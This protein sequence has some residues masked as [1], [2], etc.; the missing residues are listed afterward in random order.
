[1]E[2]GSTQGLPAETPRTETVDIGPES[3]E[4]PSRSDKRP[5]RRLPWW[6]GLVLALGIG[7][8][9]LLIAARSQPTDSA[10]SEPIEAAGNAVAEVSGEADGPSRMNVPVADPA[11]TSEIQADLAGALTGNWPEDLWLAVRQGPAI[12]AIHVESGE[13]QPM[14][15]PGRADGDG[16]LASLDGQL[17]YVH[18]ASAWL[19]GLGGEST[20]LGLADRVQPAAN[21]AHVWLGVD[22]PSTSDDPEAFV[23]WSEV[24]ATG[25][26]YRTTRREVD[27]EFAHPDLV[28]GFDSNLYR[29]EARDVHPW[30]HI[31]QGFPVAVGPNDLILNICTPER[32]C[33]RRWFDGQTGQDR[34]QLMADV[35]DNVAERYGGQLSPNGRFV[36]HDGELGRAMVRSTA[37]GELVTSACLRHDALAWAPGDA[38]LA[39]ESE[40]G[41]L[42]ATPNAATV[43]IETS[44]TAF[45]FIS[46]T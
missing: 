8:V 9:A 41:L 3:H 1:M 28:G 13:V 31:A 6:M 2:G 5:T 37:S 19:V 14:P 18:G 43:V 10:A 22:E 25:T 15:I 12:Q 4:R 17:V 46:G 16:P 44:V 33:E 24:D 40:A 27:M 38:A 35:A 32:D 29:L 42:V 45:A 36:S 30:R 11:P 20:V 34:G 26:V 21:P 23:L 39:C 7:G